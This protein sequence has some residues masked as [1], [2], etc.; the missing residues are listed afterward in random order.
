[1][2]EIASNHMTN[3]VWSVTIK[4]PNRSNGNSNSQTVQLVL[5][6]KSTVPVFKPGF[7]W[8]E[9]M[10]CCVLSGLFMCVY[11]FGDRLELCLVVVKDNKSLFLP[12]LIQAKH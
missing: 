6:D 9:S 8:L 2:F 7:D 11:V 5:I 10:L 4:T 3:H 12:L 1:M